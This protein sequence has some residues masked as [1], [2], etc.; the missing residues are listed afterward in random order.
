MFVTHGVPFFLN[1][2]ANVFLIFLNEL[3][4]VLILSL[5]HAWHPL[6]LSIH[7]SDNGGDQCYFNNYILI[8]IYLFIDCM[9]VFFIIMFY[10][11]YGLMSEIKNY[12]YY[13]Y[14]LSR[15]RMN[16]WLQ[17]IS[18]MIENIF[19]QKFNPQVIIIE[20]LKV[21]NLWKKQHPGLSNVAIDS[22]WSHC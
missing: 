22:I 13:Y 9:Y 2:C 5:P 16:L 7:Q 19:L 11:V 17:L 18:L 20:L 3:V 6:Y 10:C 1:C 8:V 15:V 14:M 21:Y 12:Y 4:W